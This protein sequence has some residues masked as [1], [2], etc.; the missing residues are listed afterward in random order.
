[1]A[2][3]GTGWVAIEKSPAK[4]KPEEIE[5][6]RYLADKGYKVTLKDEGSDVKTPDGYL[7]SSSFEQR[8]PTAKGEKGF[9]KSLEHAKHKRAKVAVVY[10]KHRTYNRREVES[11]I[12][13]YE[14][15]NKFRFEKIIV[16]GSNGSV[17]VHSHND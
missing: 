16:I 9:S 13:R 14:S 12:R 8:T 1:M 17:H 11:G 7:F 15:L 6:A 5:A 3:N 4:H 2:E 10:D